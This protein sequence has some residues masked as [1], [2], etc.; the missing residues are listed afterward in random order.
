MIVGGLVVG[1][2]LLNR[3]KAILSLSRR[4]AVRN[5]DNVA[6]KFAKVSIALVLGDFFRLLPINVY[7]DLRSPGPQIFHQTCGTSRSGK[8]DTCDPLPAGVCLH[9]TDE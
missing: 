4:T 7:E 8:H 9:E 1:F 6:K 2:A 3:S 5:Q